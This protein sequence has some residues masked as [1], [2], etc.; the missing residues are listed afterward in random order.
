MVC[1]VLWHLLPYLIWL[2]QV[3]SWPEIKY[4]SCFFLVYMLMLTRENL[5]SLG[6]LQR[7]N[8]VVTMLAVL[9]CLWHWCEQFLGIPGSTI[10]SQ[11]HD[12]RRMIYLCSAS[13]FSYIKCGDNCSS[14]LTGWW[15]L[16]LIMRERG[17]AQCLAKQWNY[18]YIYGDL[19]I[20]KYVSLKISIIYS[21]LWL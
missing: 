4:W 21:L 13:V 14:D 19:N 11:L 15:K 9:G 3:K 5:Q 7:R 2:L 12:H 6:W 16:N 20:T 17:L 18:I 10:V 1:K 8:G